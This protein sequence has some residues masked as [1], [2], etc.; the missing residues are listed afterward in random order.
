MKPRLCAV[1]D[2][3]LNNLGFSIEL[4]HACDAAEKSMRFLNYLVSNAIAAAPDYKLKND[5]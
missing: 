3:S 5:G 4:R 2:L 1:N